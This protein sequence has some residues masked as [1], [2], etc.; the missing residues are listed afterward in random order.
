MAQKQKNCV[1]DLCAQ[2][3]VNEVKLT[4]VCPLY[5]K[6]ERRIGQ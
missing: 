2:V 6:Q 1:E 3:E 5:P 4:I